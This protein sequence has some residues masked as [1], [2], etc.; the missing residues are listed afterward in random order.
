[1]NTIS[2]VWR[3]WTAAAQINPPPSIDD[4]TDILQTF[5]PTVDDLDGDAWFVAVAVEFDRLAI[6]VQPTYVQLRNFVDGN[7]S[8]SNELFDA[9]LLAINSLPESAIV[10]LA[11]ALENDTEAE[12]TIDANIAII[13]GNKTGGVNQQLDDAYDQAIASLLELKVLLSQQL[14]V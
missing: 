4:A 10:N 11:L 3:A 5:A 14:G 8:G 1:M 12:S 6:I 2:N 7:E 13:E 9:L